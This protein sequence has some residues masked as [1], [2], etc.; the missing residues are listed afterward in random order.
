MSARDG[1]RVVTIVDANGRLVRRYRRG[2]DGRERN[3]IDNRRFYGTASP[4]ASARSGSAMPS[5]W[6]GRA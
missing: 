4:S 5:T 2:P 1:V 3:I 6:P